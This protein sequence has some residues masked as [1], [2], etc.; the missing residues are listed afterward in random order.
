MEE[1]IQ[2]LRFKL[3]SPAS[4]FQKA[5]IFNELAWALRYENTKESL[6][7][8]GE[9]LKL[10]Q[11]IDYNRGIAYGKLHQAV[12]N[13]LLSHGEELVKNLLDAREY[14]ES[15]EEEEAGL[16]IC[17]NFLAR[18]YESYG[19]YEHGLDYAQKALKE[20]RKI[21]YRE[22]EG[23]ILSNMGLIYSRLCDFEQALAMYEES[24]KIRKELNHTKAIASSMNLIARVYSLTGDY[25]KALEYYQKTLDLRT[26]ENDISGLP[27]THLGIASLKEKTFNLE[28]AIKYYQESL[29]LNESV[30]EKR[31][32]IQ[33][34]LGLGRIY[35]EQ[36]KKEK[37]LDYLHR[38]LDLAEEIK[39]KPL[40]Y[41]I[42][43][44]LGEIYEMNNEFGKA[45]SHYKLYQKIEREVIS[46]ESQ[47]RLKNQQIA[48]AVEQ[49]KREAEIYQLKN[50]E[51]KKAYDEIEEK[52]TE[53]TDSI[54]YA[55]R[56]QQAVL[57][58]EEAFTKFMPEH[59]IFFRP[60][61]IVSGDFYWMAQKDHQTVFVAA[62]CTGHGIPGAFMSMLGTSFLN[63]IVGG[64][65]KLQANDIL[66]QLREQVI[67]S[68]HQT[69]REGETKDGMDLALCI[70][71]KEKKQIQ[72]SGAYNSLYFI[73]NG[74]LNEIK[75]DRMPIA[76]HWNTDQTFTNHEIQIESGDTIY[77]FSDGY[78]DQF[79]GP[80][81]K[82]FLYKQFR[83]LLLSVQDYSMEKQKDVLEKNFDEW[84]G[85]SPQIDD[86]IVM[87]IRF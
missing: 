46:A 29:R 81:G 37:G 41:E 39:A 71:D 48:F 45:L 14:F 11:E 35:T 58:P 15:S 5:D 20:A 40:L 76:I 65:D 27:W 87:G 42:H 78:A 68:L 52:N 1:R 86:V 75:A 62:D 6:E 54:R 23:D 34:L 66:E 36:K 19:D 72:Y 60:R 83:D 51:L 69:G 22:G 4:S 74:E 61:D 85:E 16:P 30:G 50:V 28:D 47:N 80:E 67:R 12:A 31:L 33:C 49:S 10:S 59:F 84:K 8:S 64:M 57:P 43:L 25:S 73:R 77:I 53:I 44:A 21:G 26:R 63:E 7:L 32:E 17:L 24:L 13:F 9:A 38:A 70:Y 55:L 18:V 3:R 82:K 56:I 79:G 2:I